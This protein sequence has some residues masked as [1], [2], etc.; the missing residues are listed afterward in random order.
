[1]EPGELPAFKFEFQQ[2]LGLNWRHITD[3]ISIPDL[4][5]GKS[6]DALAASQLNFAYA[7]TISDPC[8]PY[9]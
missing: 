4:L 3:N 2:G 8:K 7:D 9:K 6:I 5:T 1:M